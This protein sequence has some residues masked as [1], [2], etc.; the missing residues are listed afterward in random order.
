M[1]KMKIKNKRK[2]N[3][4]VIK[5]LLIIFLFSFS[6]CVT[7]K[8]FVRNIDN[9]SFL[10]LLLESGNS[11]IERDSSPKIFTE[12]IGLIAD[13]DFKK[14]VSLLKN[15][16][17]LKDLEVKNANSLEEEEAVPE[18]N[19]VKDPYQKAEVNNPIVYLYNT[20]QSEEYATSNLESYNVKP[21]VMMM[22]YILREK[23]NDKGIGTIVEE[24]DVTEFLRTNNWNYASSYKVTKLLMEDAY[25]KNPSLEYFIDL[26][27][28]SVKKSITSVT[29]DNKNYAKILFI[30][31]LENKDYAK[32]LK[33]TEI[34]NDKFNEKYPGLS[35]GI[36]KKK[37]SGVNGVYNQDFHPNTIL[38]EVGGVDN[39]IDEVFNTCLAISEI[40]TEYIKEVK[41]EE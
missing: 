30:V 19:Y 28:D 25:S 40:L 22:S 20:H 14:P 34:L 32:N 17:V 21:T 1:R 24:N 33:F 4:L 12:L 5:L 8:Y 11:H 16:Y 41:N 31:G 38:I 15:N 13:I 39:T 23:L 18:S 36:Y 26:H 6:F 3:I 27:R 10:R 9:E 37:G 7:I 29:I 35:R 2:R